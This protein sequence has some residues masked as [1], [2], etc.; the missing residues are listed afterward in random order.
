MCKSCTGVSKPIDCQDIARHYVAA[1]SGVYTVWVG[2][3]PTPVYCNISGVG[4]CGNR[5]YRVDGNVAP[6][7]AEV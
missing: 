7:G 2:G 4:L 6:H 1:P 5:I 3:V